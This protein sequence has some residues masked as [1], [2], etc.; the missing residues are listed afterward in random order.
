MLTRFRQHFKFGLLQHHRSSIR[1]FLLRD[2]RLLAELRRREALPADEVLHVIA[3][4]IGRRR[5]EADFGDDDLSAVAPLAG[6]AV[7]PGARP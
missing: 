5:Q 4:A 1:Y 3:A 6:L 2:L 7:V